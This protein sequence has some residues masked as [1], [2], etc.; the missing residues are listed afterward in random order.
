M[1]FSYIGLILNC[2]NMMRLLRVDIWFSILLG[3]TLCIKYLFSLSWQHYLLESILGGK[4]Q[5]TLAK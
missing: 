5:F 1:T 3:N 2:Q 4:L